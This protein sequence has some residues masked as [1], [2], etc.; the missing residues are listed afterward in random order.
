MKGAAASATSGCREPRVPAQGITAS[1]TDAGISASAA[2]R[3][4]GPPKHPAL[5]ATAA[6]V[7]VAMYSA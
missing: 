3:P 5:T 2:R 7:H 6:L 1:G 4:C